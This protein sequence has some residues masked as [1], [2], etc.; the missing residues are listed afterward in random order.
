MIQVS[1]WKGKT[2]TTPFLLNAQVTS[3]TAWLS[4]KIYKAKLPQYTTEDFT[5][6]IAY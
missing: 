1:L 4:T 2:N 6:Y 5:N 3:D